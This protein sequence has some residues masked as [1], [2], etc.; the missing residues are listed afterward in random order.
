MIK[1]FQFCLNFAFNF[2]MRRYAV[3]DH[4]RRSERGTAL[5]WA[6]QAVR[7]GQSRGLELAKL[8]VAAGADAGFVGSYSEARDGG[9]FELE[10]TPRWLAAL[11]DRDGAVD[12]TEL[13][14]LLLPSVGAGP[15]AGAVAAAGAEAGAGAW[16]GAG[17]GAAV[18]AGPGVGAGE[19]AGAGAEVWAGAH[20]AGDAGDSPQTVLHELAP[21]DAE[22]AALIPCMSTPAEAAAA[23]EGAEVRG[24]AGK[25]V[26]V[27]ATANIVPGAR[28]RAYTLVHFS[29]QLKRIS[30]DR[31]AFRGCLGGV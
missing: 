3:G 8:L 13:V 12:G 1:C 24:V 10:C 16:V 17:A 21:G 22:G 30:W 23:M 19:G 6:A 15:G 18:G 2:N 5:W 9:D 31:G 25:G 7:T 29:A 4:G 14:S 27:V 28:A 11:A 26:G 20:L